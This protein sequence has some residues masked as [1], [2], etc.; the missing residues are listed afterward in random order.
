MIQTQIEVRPWRTG[1]EG[2][3]SQAQISPASLG[4]RFMVGTREVPIAYLRYVASTSRERWD[5]QVATYRGRLLG[6]A[7]FGRWRSGG[8]EADLAVLVVDGW[9]RRGVATALFRAMLPRCRAAGVRVLHADVAP[10]NTAARAAV[11]ALFGASVCA[12]FRDGLLHYQ[13]ALG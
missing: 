7:E 2:L 9:Q 12:A 6:W 11:S 13:I 8:D 3:V 4:S 10:G 1:D 5:G